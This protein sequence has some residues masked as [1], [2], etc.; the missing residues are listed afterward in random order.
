MSFI[1]PALYVASYFLLRF[2]FS[3]YA[4]KRSVLPGRI[5]AQSF[6]GKRRIIFFVPFSNDTVHVTSIIVYRRS[7]T[8]IETKLR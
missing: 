2:V 6:N 7:V 5:T 8:S 4:D 3:L 1:P